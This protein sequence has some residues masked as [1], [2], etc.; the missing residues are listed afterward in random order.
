MNEFPRLKTG[1]IAQY[2]ADKS[3]GYCTHVVSFVDGSEQRFGAYCKPLKIWTIRLSLLDEQEVNLLTEF[4]R[5][6]NGAAGAFSFT[7]PWDGQVY[8][9]CSF[10]SDEMPVDVKGYADHHIAVVIRENRN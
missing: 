7:D 3:T 2:P 5:N 10:Y 9:N 1:A 8:P 4:F 6:R